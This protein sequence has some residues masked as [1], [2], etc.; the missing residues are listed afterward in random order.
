M[1]EGELD[2]VTESAAGVVDE[3]EL[4][5]SWLSVDE[6]HSLMTECGHRV[7]DVIDRK[8]Y[9]VQTFVTLGQEIGDDAGVRGRPHQFEIDLADP[10]HA[11]AHRITF[12]FDG[13][14]DG[15]VKQR[16][17]NLRGLFQIADGDPDF[18]YAANIHRLQIPG[19]L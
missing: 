16:D 8:G 14:A 19:L 15:R 7:S 2:V 4:E 12:D 13:I 9:G 10:T 5:P 11:L 3:I 17:E 18:S 1:R 6:T